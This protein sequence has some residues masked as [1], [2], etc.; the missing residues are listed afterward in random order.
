M[1]L[2]TLAW[3]AVFVSCSQALPTGPPP[4]ACA[5]LRPQ[6]AGTF[7]QTPPIPV[8]IFV[9]SS[10]TP[11]TTI[12]GNRADNS[13]HLRLCIKACGDCS[14]LNFAICDFMYL[15]LLND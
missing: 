14:N 15:K 6:H 13:D 10:Y 9:P 7:P 11:G 8:D 3:V 12:Q 4:E 5:L 2:S 1:A